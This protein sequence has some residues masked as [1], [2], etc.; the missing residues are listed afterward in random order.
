LPRG[1]R[2]VLLAAA[3]WGFA[4][5]T[6][7]FIVPDVLLTFLAQ[8]GLRRALLASL[9]AACG[10]LAGGAALYAFVLAAPETATSVLLA[11]PGISPEL[12]SRV[13]VLL[14]GDLFPGL[15]AGALSGAP[16]KLFVAEAAMTGVPLSTFLTASLPARLLRFALASAASW[17]VFTRLLGGLKLRTKRLLL[18][19]FWLVFYA[20][21]F[22]AM[23]W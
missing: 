9:A 13:A 18:G 8:I 3:L 15:A 1:N 7:F 14:G 23:E 19:G 22:I 16:Y 4:E 20:G 11:V 2:L 17:L 12:V 6:L 5:A 21:Y 10:A